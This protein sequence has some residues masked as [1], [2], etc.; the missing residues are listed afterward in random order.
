MSKTK[1]IKQLTEIGKFEKALLDNANE[2]YPKNPPK[3]W[4]K[5]N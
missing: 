4:Y 1:K 2:P 3:R 5:L